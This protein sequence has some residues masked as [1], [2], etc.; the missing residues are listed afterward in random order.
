[1]SNDS[2][3]EEGVTELGRMEHGLAELHPHE[4]SE[5]T[6]ITSKKARGARWAPPIAVLARRPEK[7]VYG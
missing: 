7:S 6:L 5:I 1:M 2:V 4:P 3:T